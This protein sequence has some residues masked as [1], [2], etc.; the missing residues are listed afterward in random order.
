MLNHRLRGLLA[1]IMAALLLFAGLTAG[2]GAAAA[3]F[4][5]NATAGILI[6]ANTGQVLF[7]KN[8][9][10][11]RQP[12]SITKI[13]TLLLALKAVDSGQASLDEKVTISHHAWEMGGS[14]LYLEEGSSYTLGQLLEAVAVASANDAA[15]AVAE[16]IGGTETAFVQMMNDEAKSL[17]M[18]D[19]T[20]TNPH[21]LPPD[22]G[23][24]P[25]VT[26]AHDIAIMAR[27]LVTKHPE[28]LKWTSEQKI[29]FHEKDPRI[30]R[31]STNKLL[32]KYD[33]LDGLKTGETAAAGW[34]LVGTAQRGDVR[35]ISV[36]LNAGSDA[37]RDEQTAHLLDYGFN[38]FAPVSVVDPGKVAGTLSLRDG[39][40]GTFDVVAPA[41]LHVLIPKG[42]AQVSVEKLIVAKPDI[43]LPLKKGDY[44][45][46]LQAIVNGKPVLSTPVTAAV[47]V[48]RA[49]FVVR[50]FRWFGSWISGLLHGNG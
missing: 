25:D 37:G 40:P 9:D 38:R 1:P 12:A 35:L 46:N 4:D 34:C 39:A 47:D 15:M 24:D 31:Y 10:Q 50:F 44:V 14:Q 32:G 11:K 18:K 8:A 19:T 49:N 33:G 29:V 20:F 6:D 2:A 3:T 23:E 21:G 43:Q 13:M 17:G 36:V 7:A 30:V 28:V 5:I 48:H 45:G 16:H 42:D 22:P 41:G 26:T 27:E